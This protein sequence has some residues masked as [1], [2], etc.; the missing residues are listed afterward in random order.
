MTG[1]IMNVGLQKNFSLFLF[2]KTT[3]TGYGMSEMMRRDLLS[4]E[5]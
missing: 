1:K 2:L 4:L 3:A 5:V